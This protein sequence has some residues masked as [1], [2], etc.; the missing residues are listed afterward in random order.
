MQNQT[1][2]NDSKNLRTPYST[3]VL[4]LGIISIPSCICYGIVGLTTGIIALVLAAKGKALFDA[5]PYLYTNGS[6]ANLN[7]GKVCAIVGV[8]L[9]GLLFL[10]FIAI[11]SMYGFVLSQFPWE[12]LR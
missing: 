6:L 8:S 4:V 11:F 12:Q 10:Y 9:S 5:A 2:D 3:A 7:A 1:L